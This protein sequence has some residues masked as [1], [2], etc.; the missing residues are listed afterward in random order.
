MTKVNYQNFS[1]F[2]FSFAD[3]FFGS[4]NSGRFESYGKEGKCYNNKRLPTF[5]GSVIPNS[6]WLICFARSASRFGKIEENNWE[7][8]FHAWKLKKESQNVSAK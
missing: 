6:N 8:L 4:T 3:S 7:Y 2:W 1:K 5:L